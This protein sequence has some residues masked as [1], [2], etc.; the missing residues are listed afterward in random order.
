VQVEL[1][2]PSND[3]G[4]CIERLDKI[5]EWICFFPMNGEKIKST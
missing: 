1:R 2:N 5:Q 3:L 4:D